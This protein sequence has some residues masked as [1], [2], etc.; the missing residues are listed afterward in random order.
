MRG[1]ATKPQFWIERVHHHQTTSVES[2][3]TFSEL[4]SL[5]FHLSQ[6]WKVPQICKCNFRNLKWDSFN[7]LGAHLLL[8]KYE[9]KKSLMYERNLHEM[10]E[11]TFREIE[12]KRNLFDRT[13]TSLPF[14]K[15]SSK[16]ISNILHGT[17]HCII[18]PGIIWYCMVYSFIVWYCFAL[19]WYYRNDPDWLAYCVLHG[20]AVSAGLGRVAKYM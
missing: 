13:A 15:V 14:I 1:L 17:Y 16:N 9:N 2:E 6:S 11:V 4:Q 12:Q 8:L 7:A 10:F 5:S 3:T 20:T 19:H 18:L